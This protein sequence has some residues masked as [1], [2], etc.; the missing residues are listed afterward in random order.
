MSIKDV[1]TSAPVV[2]G[3]Y[4]GTAFSFYLFLKF[5]TQIEE[6]F[7]E[8]SICFGK[9]PTTPHDSR[10]DALRHHFPASGSYNT[11]LV[12]SHLPQFWLARGGVN[13]DEDEPSRERERKRN[14]P[15]SS[16]LLP[17]SQGAG[18]QGRWCG[19]GLP[20]WGNSKKQ[21]W[22]PPLQSLLSAS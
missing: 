15:R 2:W 20:E 7:Q 6:Y 14:D 4:L 18:S 9:L 12:L 16:L 5:W 1:H 22:A 10:T 19:P 8:Y 11:C 13:S 17:G 21:A 3:K